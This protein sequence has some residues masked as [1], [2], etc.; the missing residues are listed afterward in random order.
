MSKFTPT[1]SQKN[2]IEARGNAI[3]ISAGAGSGKTK[4]LTERLM[5]Y[6]LDEKNPQ[7]VVRFVLITY[8]Q[9][10]AEELRSRISAELSEAA[11]SAEKS[12]NAALAAHIRCQ[13]ALCRKAMIG[14][15]HHF[16]ASI[17]RENGHMLGLPSDFKI[18]SNER[19]EAMKSAALD[20]VLSQRYEKISTCPGF[21][22]LVNSVGTG[23]DDSRLAELVLQL[24]E[25]MRCHPRPETWAEEQVEELKHQHND[26][27]KTKWGQEI[28]WN[29]R[30]I[31]SYW[32]S[33]MDR[34]IA[35]M[36]KDEV[37]WKAYGEAVEQGAEGVRAMERALRAGWEEART[38]EATP[39]GKFNRVSKDYHPELTELVKARRDACKADMEKVKKMLYSDSASLSSEMAE[40]ALQMEALLKL[41][42]DFEKEY[43]ADKRAGSMLD[44]SDLEHFAVSLLTDEEG[45]PSEVAKNIAARYTEIMVDEYQ[46]VSRV[47][48]AVFCAVSRE[49]KNLFMVGDV[50]QAIYRFRLADPEIFNEKYREYPHYPDTASQ[51]GTKILLRE[52]FRSRR[53][54][55]DA[56]NSVFSSC[57][58]KELGDIDYD[59][60]ASL[61]CGATGYEGT[62][63]PPE[64]DIFTKPD[65]EKDKTAYEAARVADRICALISSK[66]LVTDGGE[67]RPVEYGDIAILLR[68]ANSNGGVY[69]RA[70]EKRGIPVSS[71]Q[72]GGLFETREVSFVLSMLRIMDNPHTDIPLLAALSSPVFGFSADELAEIRTASPKTDLYD[73]LKAYALISEKAAKFTALLT[74]FREAAPDMT[75]EKLIRMI[76]MKTDLLPVCGAMK[77][78]KSRIANL[79]QL[80]SIG[81]NFEADGYHG[82]HRFVLYLSR[83]EEK[84]SALT[85]AGAENAAVRIL[86][87]HRSKGLEFPVVFL[88]DTAHLFNM[89]DTEDTVVVHPTLGLG[90]KRTDRENLIQYPTL[91]RKAIALRLK[92][93]TLSEEMRLLYVALT[94]PKERLFITAVK[95]DPNAFVAKQRMLL[96]LE[97][98]KPEAEMLA[99]AHSYIEWLT[100][101]ALADGGKTLCLR[102]EPAEENASEEAPLPVPAEENTVPEAEIAAFKERMEF[103]YPFAASSVLPSKL[104]ATELKHFETKEDEDAAELI[105]S[106]RRKRIFRYPDFAREEKTLTG[107][108]R[109]I[110]THLALQYMD[111]SKAFSAEGIS[112]EITRLKEQRYL[113][114][115][116]AEAVSLPAIQKLFSSALGERIRNADAVHREFRFSVLCNAGELLKADSSDEI[117]LQGVVDCCLEEGGEL[118]I[119]DYK[120]DHVFTEAQVQ[121]RCALY[122]GQVKAYAMALGRIFEKPVK[123]TVL[124][125]LSCDRM[126]SLH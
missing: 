48:E 25:K 88:C 97:G 91:A 37:V 41:T 47:Q 111:I 82:L 21:E 12:G 103:R 120:T 68:N 99:S 110:A 18:I 29:A 80:I 122:A 101:A 112:A 106:G 59:G 62:V 98:G 52:N 123:E 83:L 3:L 71:G 50:K 81:G 9:D 14:T 126:V 42:L 34:L 7:S 58:S 69:R 39:F 44:Y 94:R 49:R 87:I 30:S 89:K 31:V 24:Y 108:E 78:G 117:L 60:D 6:I 45:C 15:I 114:E 11:A 4:V 17:L 51:K 102:T 13:Q 79:M 54:I 26:L 53:E 63:P 10:S 38:C 109:G 2:A 46:D 125:F 57:M 121:E 64:I 67:R 8:T 105:P 33:E 19:A 124:Y 40:T 116:Q 22:E 32:S 72:G 77:D 16:C 66:A 96:P 74:G 92:K 27:S 43:S 95:P 118:V 93:E 75:A 73:A 100:V 61:L 76:L 5:R 90:P 119:I 28:L 85:A 84:N 115:R 70:L 86:S 113:S 1:A 65:S 107:A 20:K 23:R 56:A 104:T 35:L 36:R 55:L